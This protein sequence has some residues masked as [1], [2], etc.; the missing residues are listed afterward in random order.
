MAGMKKAKS[1]YLIQ[2]VSRALDILEAF[3][4]GQE[5]LGVT[6]LSRKLKL[7]KNN[8]FRL[9]ATLETRGYVEQD[10]ETGNYR[11][12]IKTFEVAS[13]FLH[14]LGL[15]TQAHSALDQLAAETTETAY[16]GVLEGPGVVCVDMAETTHAVR[17]VSYLGQRLPAHA[18]ALGKAQLAFRPQDELEQLWKQYEPS[19]VTPRTL[20]DPARLGEELARVAA[21]EVALEDEESAPG[22]RGVAAPVRDYQKRVVGAVGV[23]GPVFR[24]T[25]ERLQ[26][27]L[28]PRVKAA[29]QAVSKRLG[30]AAIPG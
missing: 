14:H 13:V 24:L 8:V 17:V 9:L 16:L 2:S 7:H 11:L 26:G 3:A 28:V 27:E 29:A 30:Y 25:L 10:K 4:V 22:V 6:E 21:E 1:D 18:S 23:V 5:E 15:A 12:G 19:A 20:T